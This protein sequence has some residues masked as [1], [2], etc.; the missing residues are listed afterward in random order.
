MRAAAATATVGVAAAVVVVAATGYA[1]GGSENHTARRVIPRALLRDDPAEAAALAD[2]ARAANASG[3]VHSSGWTDPAATTKSRSICEWF[4]VTCGAPGS[5]PD[6]GRVI[7]IDLSSNNLNGSIPASIG[8]LSRL[9]TFHINGHRPDSYM[10]C[11]DTDMRGSVVPEVGR[12]K[13]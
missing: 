7:A 9:Q 1:A 10:G 11:K 3:W 13:E 4:G 12:C 5:G 8:A 2:L 6:E